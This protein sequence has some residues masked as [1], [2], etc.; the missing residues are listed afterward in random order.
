MKSRIEMRSIQLPQRRSRTSGYPPQRLLFRAG[1]AGR[2]K[3]TSFSPVRR[4]LPHDLDKISS[5][6][7]RRCLDCTGPRSFDWIFGVSDPPPE[8]GHDVTE[9]CAVSASA[10]SCTAADWSASNLKST[11][12][13]MERP[14][15][16]HVPDLVSFQI[17]S[18]VA[19]FTGYRHCAGGGSILL[20]WWLVTSRRRRAVTTTHAL[21]FLR[22]PCAVVRW[23]R[24]LLL[25]LVQR[26]PSSAWDAG[27][28]LKWEGCSERSLFRRTGS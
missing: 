27:Y 8:H 10:T 25:P 2:R 12:H 14:Y 21:S 19:I 20:V 1:I 9:C 11:E 15:R 4:G 13:P 24:R 23:F 18:A 7:S 22:S 6:D 16:L 26:R 3:A 5:G 28:G 17:T